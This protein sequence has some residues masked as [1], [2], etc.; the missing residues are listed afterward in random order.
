MPEIGQE[1]RCPTGPIQV[2]N[3]EFP[4]QK[5]LFSKHDA[6]VVEPITKCKH[7]HE[8]GIARKHGYAK[9]HEAVAQVQRMAH[10]RVCIH[11]VEPVGHLSFRIPARSAHGCVAYGVGAHKQSGQA[12]AEAEA[13]VGVPMVDGCREQDSRT[14]DDK[15]QSRY[16]CRQCHEWQEAPTAKQPVAL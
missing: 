16:A 1:C 12:C 13:L 9:P 15:Q 10:N 7:C 14:V 3:A 4:A 5:L 6:L 8:S 2:G 11:G